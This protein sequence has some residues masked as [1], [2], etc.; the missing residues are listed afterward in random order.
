MTGV[1]TCALPI[2]GVAHL[3]DIEFEFVSDE[4][5]GISRDTFG[6]IRPRLVRKLN[7]KTANTE[8]IESRVWLGVDWIFDGTEGDKLGAA[9]ADQVFVKLG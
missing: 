2:Y 8:N 5:N 9:V 3:K 7:L 6:A 4:Y 1:Q